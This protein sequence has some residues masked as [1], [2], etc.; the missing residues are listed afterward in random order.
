MTDKINF[1]NIY[2]K[3]H[4]YTISIAQHRE[5]DS[6]NDTITQQE[7][8]V[9]PTDTIVYYDNTIDSLIKALQSL[10]DVDK[11]RYDDDLPWC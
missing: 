1:N 9:L 7:I 3:H 6:P 5:G 11:Y 8:M 10:V 2:I 4:G